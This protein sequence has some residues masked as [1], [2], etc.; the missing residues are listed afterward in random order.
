MR[1]RRAEHPARPHS[2]D[3]QC[4]AEGIHIE[5]NGHRERANSHKGFQ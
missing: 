5:V 4:A 2:S 3:I 1:G